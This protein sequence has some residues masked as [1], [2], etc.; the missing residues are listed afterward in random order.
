MTAERQPFINTQLKVENPLRM[1]CFLC[2]LPRSPWALVF[3]Y[4]VPVCRGCVNYEGADRIAHVIQCVGA[5]K[6]ALLQNEDKNKA[7]KVPSFPPPLH[8]AIITLYMDALRLFQHQQNGFQYLRQMQS[9]SHREFR[10]PASVRSAR[11]SAL[12][13]GLLH[14]E[15][16]SISDRLFFEYPTGSGMLIH[17]VKKL[18]EQMDVV[19]TELEFEIQRGCWRRLEEALIYLQQERTQANCLTCGMT[20]EGSHFVQCPVRPLHKFCFTCARTALLNSK[21]KDNRVSKEEEG[22]HASEVRRRFHCPSGEMCALP[23]TPAV[24][25]SFVESE[26]AVILGGVEGNT[27]SGATKRRHASSV[28]NLRH[29]HQPSRKQTSEGKVRRAESSSAPAT[30]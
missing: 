19:E 11:K 2:E 28:L 20:L 9:I 17:G 15:N 8:S 25:W 16:G 5:Q 27:S 30:A 6:R 13:V 7:V 14:D 10:F 26:I 1:Q 3:D 18:L 24:P 12:C 4:S 22:G 21:L 29:C 23:D